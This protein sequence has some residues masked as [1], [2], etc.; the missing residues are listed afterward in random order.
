M[1]SSFAAPPAADLPVTGQVVRVR[2][3]HWVV[4]DVRSSALPPDVKLADPDE[5]Q[6]LVTLSSVEE[7]A[8]GEELRVLWELEPGRLVRDTAT[9]PDL[10][11]ARVDEPDT[12]AAFLDAI[13][14]GAITNADADLMQA[15]FRSGIAIEDFQLDPLVRALGMPRVNLL[16]A[17]DVGLGK[18]IE[19]G[20]VIQEMLLRHRARRVMVVCPATLMTKWRDEMASRFGLDFKIV[21]S[22]TSREVR[23]ER[24]LNANPFKLYPLTIVSMAWLRGPRCQRLLTEILAGDES[25]LPRPID[26][27]IVD[28]AHHC[29]PPG[30]GHY[31][32]DSQQTRAV[33]RL[34][35]HAEHRLFLS[36]TPH[37]GY[38]ESWTALLQMLDPQ[39]FV[40]GVAPSTSAL[41]QVM[42]RRMKSELRNEDGTRKYPDRDVQGITIEYAAHDRDAHQLLKGYT[43]ARRR[44]LARETGKAAARA[45]DLVTLL[46][47][48]RLC[49]SPFAFAITLERHLQTLTSAEQVDAE[50]DWI[51]DAHSRLLYDGFDN[52]E[53]LDA[54]EASVVDVAIRAS[55]GGHPS[56]QDL[57]DRLHSWTV[58]HGQEADAKAHA[59]VTFLTDVCKNAD[60]SW[61]DERVVVFT[62]YRDTARWLA[63]LLDR[64]DLA[65]HGRLEQ[66]YGG[67]DDKARE[68]ITRDFQTPPQLHPVR[69]LLA[70][71]T[72]SE[73]ID[74]QDQCHRLINYDIPFNPNRLEQR[75][76][77]IDRYGQKQVP[78]VFHFVGSHWKDAAPGSADADLDFLARVASKVQQ[79]RDDLGSVN[80]VI[81]AAVERRMLGIEDSTFLVERVEPK[82]AA[83]EALKVERDLRA[84]VERLRRILRDSEA[85]LHARP[86]DIHRVLSTGLRLG[87]QLPLEPLPDERSGA[88]V[89]RVPALTGAWAR[90]V[91]DLVDRDYGQRDISF[92]AAV[93]AGR[94]DLVLAHLNHPLVAMATR[95]LRAEV[96]GKGSIARA[97]S[98]V[99]NDAAVTDQVLAVYSRLVLVGQDGV[100]LHEELFPAGGLVRGTAFSRLGV[101]D[102][103]RALDAALAPGMDPQPAD[104]RHLTDI[105][106]R[107]GALSVGLRAAVDARAKERQMSLDR[108]LGR[109][110]DDE[111][112]RVT[113]LLDAFDKS[114][115]T[116][117]DQQ[118]S[119]YQAAFDMFEPD[120]RAQLQH[121]QAAW[122]ARLAALPAERDAELAAIDSRYKSARVLVFPAAVVHLVPARSHR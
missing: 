91:T 85:D 112:A 42:V 66:L 43:E 33:S 44:R 52:D 46:L 34:S 71:D 35:L 116:A 111:K 110:R 92:D 3:R 86:A 15:P 93:A 36:A 67:M 40:R 77:R 63:D 114:L 72:A 8:L 25:Q 5:G 80:P 107:W 59:L 121:D 9:L 62:E 122:R 18:T 16:V 4:T 24:G 113:T 87:V 104:Q 45:N 50:E 82:A 54:E 83:R 1:S 70:T 56:E 32:I 96:W 115:R 109:R 78:Q 89:Y 38:M 7:D 12:L 102:L 13:R 94:K 105:A 65:D 81:A 75:A 53:T 57:L 10:S 90:T 20:L 49:S 69:I 95:L 84:Q 99:V 103:G 2:G 17:D 11:D 37:N 39:R 106:R 26:L 28:E 120:E 48:K 23:R 73:G 29:A 51:A 74:L 55:A 76:G 21:D 19:A 118:T 30:Q 61:N 101:N 119:D 41:N 98:L 58:E 117:I 14:W 27:L 68:R 79:M 47:K 64:Y 100:R 6:T 97:A 60:R 108:S 88:T 22:V 31:A